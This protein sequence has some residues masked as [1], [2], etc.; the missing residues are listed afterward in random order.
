MN[1]QYICISQ[2]NPLL[3]KFFFSLVL[4]RQRK[5]GCYRL[6]THRQMEFF[7]SSLL[8]LKSKFWPYVYYCDCYATMGSK[9]HIS[10]VEIAEQL[11][12]IGYVQLVQQTNSQLIL[13][14][15]IL[16]EFHEYLSFM[17]FIEHQTITVIYPDD[18]GVFSSKLDWTL[19]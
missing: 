1:N 9:V 5:K 17:I 10:M 19:S 4:E 18:F 13:S 6:P 2:F 12:G 3:H 16:Y 15:W 7:Q 8:I 11:L 14:K